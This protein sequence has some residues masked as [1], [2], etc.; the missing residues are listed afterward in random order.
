MKKL[1][2]GAIWL[3]FTGAIS[4]MIMILV[5]KRE[6]CNY[7]QKFRRVLRNDESFFLN[8]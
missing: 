3:D 8:E 7:C 1:S 4:I 5:F 2:F 6:L